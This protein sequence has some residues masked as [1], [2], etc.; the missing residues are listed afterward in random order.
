MP[1]NA[2]L[3]EGVGWA[4][5]TSVVGPPRIERELGG[6]GRTVGRSAIA[7]PRQVAERDHDRFR[8][9]P[10]CGEFGRDVGGRGI[11]DDVDGRQPVPGKQ[12]SGG[13]VI[14]GALAVPVSGGDGGD[15]EQVPVG[16]GDV[17][18]R[19][20]V[21]ADGRLAEPRRRAGGRQ[22]DRGVAQHVA[23]GR[24]ESPGVPIVG[25]QD[26]RQ[27]TKLL[28]VPHREACRRRGVTAGRCGRVTKDRIDEQPHAADV[29]D[30]RCRAEG[31]Q[32]CRMG[33]ARDAGAGGLDARG[34][35]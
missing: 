7:V 25:D 31:R 23:S 19:P 29:Q 22:G 34:E 14:M 33:C 18:H 30:E 3:G 16:P 20:R 32:I 5:T 15:L 12:E 13:P 11:A 4:P 1:V 6:R 28:R 10:T 8:D 9:R 21:Q 17:R 2:S 27:R 26:A 35:I 24:V